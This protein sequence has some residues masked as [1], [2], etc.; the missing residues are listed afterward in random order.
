[1]KTIRVESG[2]PYEVL[3]A[4][5]LLPRVGEL[6]APFAPR[7]A[8]AA[9]VTDG[10]VEALYAATMRQS[11]EEAGFRTV[12]FSF[13]AGERS[14]TLAT[15]EAALSFF[16]ANEVTRNDLV[17]A[18]GG[19]VPGD[20]A[21]FAA[22]T[23]L[24]GIRFLQVPTTLLAAVDSSVGGKTAVDL[25]EGK[26]LV[27][28]FH[29][30]VRVVCDPDALSTLPAARFAEGVAEAVKYGVLQDRALFDLLATGDFARHLPDVVARCVSI[31]ADFVARDEFDRGARKFLNLGH[32]FG[33]AVEAASDFAVSHGEAVAIGMVAAARAAEKRGIARE[34][35]AEPLVA[36]LEANQLPTRSPLPASSLVSWALRD[37]KREGG[38]ISFVLPETIGRC[39]LETVDVG[40]IPAMFEAG[41]A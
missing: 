28:A 34:P 16:A 37:K 13:P 21:G 6:A 5:G 10:T 14:K 26:N 27:G 8:T 41:L 31:K 7:G 30:P 4:R 40:E 25:P 23:Y 17:V 24:R 32:T 2:R 35:L 15:Y 11:L 33:H 9:V 1:M 39:R 3:V 19:G 20:L 38:T 18:L 12:L 36:A 29:Q 22:A